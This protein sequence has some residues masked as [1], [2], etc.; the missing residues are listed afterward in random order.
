M[1]AHRMWADIFNFLLST[2]GKTFLDESEDFVFTSKKATL[3][4][5]SK[6]IF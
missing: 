1:V 6:D 3:D 2:H 4:H 5:T